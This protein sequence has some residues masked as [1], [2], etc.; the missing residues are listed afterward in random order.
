MDNKELEER[1]R[2]LDFVANNLESQIYALKSEINKLNIEKEKLRK[3]Q[4]KVAIY[5]RELWNYHNYHQNYT[6]R[7]NIPNPTYVKA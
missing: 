4:I 2:Q 7:E 5:T 3:S 6:T 1:I